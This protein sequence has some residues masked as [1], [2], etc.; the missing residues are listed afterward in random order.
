[1]LELV[2][3]AFFLAQA[4]LNS[5]YLMRLM[6]RESGILPVAIRKAKTAAISPRIT[7]VRPMKGADE[8]TEACVRSLYMA[9]SPGQDHARVIHSFET[10]DDPA[11]AVVERVAAELGDRLPTELV[12]AKLE[13][14]NPKMGN[15]VEAYERAPD[16]WVALLDN[17]VDVPSLGFVSQ[18]ERYCV[19]S[20]RAASGFIHGV[21]ASS[22]ASA[23]IEYAA[24]YSFF[25]KGALLAETFGEAPLIGKVM[26]VHKPS[27]DKLGG[28]RRYKDTFSEDGEI[29]RELSRLYGPDSVPIM[30]VEAPQRIRATS[31]EAVIG[32]FARWALYRKLRAPQLFWLEPLLYPLLITVLCAL[33]SKTALGA[34]FFAAVHIGFVCAEAHFAHLAQYDHAPVKLTYS[35]VLWAIVG[36]N[37]IL[38]LVWASAA[39]SSTVSWK[40]ETYDVNSSGD[41]VRHSI[42]HM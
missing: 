28:L 12:F 10:R 6:M 16:E 42:Q 33:G 25:G 4:A 1:M 37:L 8:T 23:R 41:M 30:H 22:D 34:M 14:A 11:V 36:S 3:Y 17:N 2:F 35:E 18:L 19:P 7:Y 31:G 5:I 15:C 24:L 20:V 13:A 38:P 32:R 26:L 27:L 9:H 39:A 29:G 40:G 21:L